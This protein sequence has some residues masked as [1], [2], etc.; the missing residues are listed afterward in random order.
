MGVRG[1]AHW[2]TGPALPGSAVIPSPPGPSSDGT[3][4]GLWREEEGGEYIRSTQ[5]EDTLPT[6]SARTDIRSWL[7]D[8]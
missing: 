5:R 2:H 3:E 1:E 8:I 7:C 4:L 6:T